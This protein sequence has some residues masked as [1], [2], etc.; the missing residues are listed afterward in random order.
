MNITPES[1]AK[2]VE[3]M[4][5]LQKEKS[6]GKAKRQLYENLDKQ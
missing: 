1:R 3:K 4:N 6:M 5:Q 2:A